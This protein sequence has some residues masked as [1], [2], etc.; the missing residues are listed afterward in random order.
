MGIR[1]DTNENMIVLHVEGDVTIGI[2]AE[3]K[4]MI[5]SAM[6]AEGP[7]S[8]DLSQAKNLDI[9]CIQLFCSA[10]SQFERHS[11]RIALNPGKNK[12]FLNKILVGSG[13]NPDGG[14]SENPCKRCVWKGEVNHG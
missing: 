9:S 4:E 14:C 10:N 7:L 2:A 3:L 8:I 5:L 12:E 6:S 1:L 11:K 13:Y